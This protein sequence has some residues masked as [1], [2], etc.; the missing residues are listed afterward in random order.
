MYLT[1][2]APHLNKLAPQV[3]LAPQGPMMLL[4]LALQITMEETAIISYE[5]QECMLL[6]RDLD[7]SNT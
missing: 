1:Y 5:K 7:N 6:L 3:R 4:R 2:G